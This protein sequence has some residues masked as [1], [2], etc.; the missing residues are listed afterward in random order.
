MKDFGTSNF[1][2]QKVILLFVLSSLPL[3]QVLLTF[4]S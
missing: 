4:V 1:C 2:V 3:Q